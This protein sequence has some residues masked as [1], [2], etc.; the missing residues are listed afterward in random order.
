METSND[1]AVRYAGRLT[2]ALDPAAVVGGQ[3]SLKRVDPAALNRP[4]A[5]I[6]VGLES[7]MESLIAQHAQAVHVDWRPAAGGN[8]KLMSILERMKS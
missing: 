6:N 8:E 2:Q 3:E 5:A 1:V 4:L 7:F